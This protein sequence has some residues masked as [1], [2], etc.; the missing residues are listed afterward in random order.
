MRTTAILGLILIGLGIL[1]LAYFAFPMRLMFHS[2]L[3][4]QEVNPLPSILG[5]LALL[6]GIVLLLVMRS[7][8][9]D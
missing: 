6:C 5:A 8:G 1:A 7:K 9:D 3:G 4:P 2:T